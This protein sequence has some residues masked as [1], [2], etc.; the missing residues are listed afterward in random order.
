MAGHLLFEDMTFEAMSFF[1]SVGA[2][3]TETIFHAD[4]AWHGNNRL[5][6][7]KASPHRDRAGLPPHAYIHFQANRI[8]IPADPTKRATLNKYLK[9]CTR[10]LGVVLAHPGLANWTATVNAADPG[11]FD[12]TEMLVAAIQNAAVTI[13]YYKLDRSLL[14]DVFRRDVTPDTAHLPPAQQRLVPGTWERVDE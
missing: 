6:V 10:P 4:R 7:Q 5:E 8:N 14:L 13:E 3:A 12:L 9:K 11:P 2:E 1:K